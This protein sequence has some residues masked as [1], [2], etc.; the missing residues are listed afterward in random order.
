MPAISVPS[1]F[2]GARVRS[3]IFKLPLFT[4]LMIFAIVAT[5]FVGVV[6]DTRWDIRA[7]GA[8]VPDEV[9]LTSC[10]WPSR[11]PSSIYLHRNIGP[12]VVCPGQLAVRS[13]RCALY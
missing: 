9:G 2:S 4:R 6:A 10:E 13:E 5:W 12:A 8:L 7:W 1:S 3:Y 11:H